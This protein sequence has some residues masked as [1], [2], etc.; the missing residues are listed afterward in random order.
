MTHTNVTYYINVDSTFL[1]VLPL[2]KDSLEFGTL[3]TM[4]MCLKR[5]FMLGFE[6]EL[7]CLATRC[8]WRGSVAFRA[9]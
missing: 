7:L 9:N 6:T 1:R 5:M 8:S 4:E 2:Q 3:F